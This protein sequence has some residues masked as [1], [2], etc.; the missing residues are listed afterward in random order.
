MP[1]LHRPPK[2]S[3]SK[4]DY[5]D[6]QDKFSPGPWAFNGSHSTA[7]MDIPADDWPVYGLIADSGNRSVCRI[8]SVPEC[9]TAD[10]RLMEKARELY[11]ALALAVAELPADSPVRAL[12]GHLLAQCRGQATAADCA[13]LRNLDV[14][15][16]LPGR[17]GERMLNLKCPQRLL[18]TECQS[19][20]Y[21]MMEPHCS[22][23]IEGA[24]AMTE[25][26]L[27]PCGW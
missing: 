5:M 15:A 21:F 19:C 1:R 7:R 14:A 2:W 12:A 25:W 22:I 10:M 13:P 27:K 23:F 26:L 11:D 8:A 20:Q 4:G 16:R 6:K 18:G 17:E 24:G 3:C 9:R